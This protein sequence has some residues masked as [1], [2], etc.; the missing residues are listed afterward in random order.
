MRLSQSLTLLLLGIVVARSP[1]AAQGTKTP[2]AP[3][4]TAGQTRLLDSL[5][6]RVDGAGTPAQRATAAIDWSEA[7]RVAGLAEQVIPAHQR[8]VQLAVQSADS[9]VLALA[10]HTMGIEY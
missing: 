9:T 6:A 8:A 5:R 2:A 4:V 7:L 10:L 3:A 1:L